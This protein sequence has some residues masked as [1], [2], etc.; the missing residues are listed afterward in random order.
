MDGTLGG[1]DGVEAILEVEHTA[2]SNSTQA[3]LQLAEIHPGCGAPARQAS[4]VRAKLR[5]AG[6]R[7][8]APDRCGTR[9]IGTGGRLRA[10]VVLFPC[11]ARA[12]EGPQDRESGSDSEQDPRAHDA[13]F[14]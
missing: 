3:H 12:A 5:R 4:A 1:H 2:R 8:D 10:Q 11:G 7:D 14:C 13:A 6:G 9:K